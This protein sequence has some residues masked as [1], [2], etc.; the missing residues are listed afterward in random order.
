[1]LMPT[2]S[3]S[4]SGAVT[5]RLQK[6]AYIAS[7]LIFV[8]YFGF[9]QV[10]RT[11]I[12][13]HSA[14]ALPNHI[15]RLSME[16][17]AFLMILFASVSSVRLKTRLFS[18]EY[19][20]VA[21][22]LTYSFMSFFIY[23]GDYISLL[24]IN[25]RSF[26]WILLIFVFACALPVRIRSINL[27]NEVFLKY[28]KIIILITISLLS[29]YYIFFSGVST[30]IG[31]TR[32]QLGGVSIH[33]N[34]LSVIGAICFL[35]FGIFGRGKGNLS[36]LIACVVLVLLANSRT[37]HLIGATSLL[38]V[39]ISRLQPLVRVA[40]LAIFAT[41]G[42]VAIIIV[43]N[44][45][46]APLLQNNIQLSSLNGRFGVWSA[47]Q[48]MFE[49]Y[50]IYGW[51]FV[52]GPEKI[53]SFMNESWWNATNAQGD[54]MSALVSGGVIGLFFYFAFFM[55]IW[56]GV[57]AKT[58]GP[59]FLFGLGTALAYSITAQFESVI[60]HPATHLSIVLLFFLRVLRVYSR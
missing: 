6:V 50:P 57:L 54:I 40:F 15:F 24:K 19:I 32:W 45:V 55:S 12:L 46:I 48:R 26:E 5:T 16:L 2:S 20:L 56:W 25:I 35:V 43:F 9:V 4:H 59:L 18:Y 23:W 31:L 37:G 52:L 7:L 11:G 34:R 28:S 53:G 41:V 42:T 13:R 49:A 60:V 14:D 58:K 47:A 22:F 29:F 33:P 8:G 38:I 51:G 39:L 44:S 17:I 27:P 36:W 30:T 1:M 3:S 10:D 21:M